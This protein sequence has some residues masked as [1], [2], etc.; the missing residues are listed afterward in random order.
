MKAEVRG[1]KTEVRDSSRMEQV[2]VAVHDTLTIR[3]TITIR[4]NERGDTIRMNTVTDR[5]RTRSMYDVRRQKEEVRVYRDTVYIERR[6][7]VQVKSEE[8][9]VKSDRAS[10]WVSALRWIFGII[11]AVIAL[12]I[13]LT[14]TK[15][16]KNLRI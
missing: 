10:G 1:V 8:I 9:K 5:E 3:K 12:T 6:D 16:I 11:V 14:I 15:T 2:M 4:E 7:S 13:T